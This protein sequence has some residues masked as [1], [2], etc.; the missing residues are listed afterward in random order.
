MFEFKGWI[1]LTKAADAGH[2]PS[3]MTLADSNDVSQS[4]SQGRDPDWCS[5]I[6]WLERT[7]E[8]IDQ[9]DANGDFD[10]TNDNPS[11]V[12]KARMASMLRTGGYGLEKDTERAGI[13]DMGDWAA[14]DTVCSPIS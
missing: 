10:S 9:S 7:L 11:Y 2:R 4:E 3:I 14:F 1:Y 8:T 13:G 6:H 12:V 5:V